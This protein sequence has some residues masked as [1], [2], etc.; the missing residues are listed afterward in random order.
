MESLFQIGINVNDE[1][2]NFIT[3]A[4]LK[5]ISITIIDKNDYMITDFKLAKYN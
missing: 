1:S 4:L 5:K 3:I 2:I